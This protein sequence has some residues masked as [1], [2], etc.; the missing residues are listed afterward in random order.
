[1]AEEFKCKFCGMIFAT[2]EEMEKHAQ[3]NHPDEMKKG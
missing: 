1:M 2:K 3:E